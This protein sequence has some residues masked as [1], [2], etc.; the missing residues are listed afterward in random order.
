M[1]HPS[2]LMIRFYKFIL[3]RKYSLRNHYFS[4]Q[5]FKYASNNNNFFC[6]FES[7]PFD[8]QTPLGYTA[9]VFIQSATVYL[10]P[11]V[12]TCTLMLTIG[13]CMLIGSF[14]SDIKEKLRQLNR[15][16]TFS[17]DKNLTTDDQVLLK[18]KLNEIIKFYA[19]TRELS[20]V[21]D[22]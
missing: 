6:L 5:Y 15:I 14:A 1:S 9:C 19:E 18:K 20:I 8:W 11:E 4:S 13:V 2:F 7:Y 22:I 17:G 16:L 12:Y 10:G 21:F 3:L